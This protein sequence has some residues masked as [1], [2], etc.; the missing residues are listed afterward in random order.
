M[1]DH[2]QASANFTR[3]MASATSRAQNRSSRVL[4]FRMD[5]SASVPFSKHA[6]RALY[7][8]ADSNRS[9]PHFD[10]SAL[11]ASPSRRML[12]SIDVSASVPLCKRA[13][14]TLHALAIPTA[15]RHIHS[16]GHG[17]IA[18]RVHLTCCS[19]TSPAPPRK[20]PGQ[21]EHR[22]RK[23]TLGRQ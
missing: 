9:A 15:R 14:R 18:F 19:Q 6:L 21:L 20:A 23:D 3:S 13:L 7:A 10:N 1:R 2:I 11:N 4:Q 16:E 12:L 17:N 22:R 8:L 5:V